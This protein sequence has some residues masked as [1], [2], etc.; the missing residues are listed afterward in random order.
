MKEVLYT[1]IIGNVVVFVLLGVHVLTVFARE[2]RERRKKKATYSQMFDVLEEKEKTKRGAPPPTQA[3]P[4]ELSDK[5][6]QMTIEEVA[7]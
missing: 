2:W 6:E 7:T 3:T 1:I 5:F 4:P